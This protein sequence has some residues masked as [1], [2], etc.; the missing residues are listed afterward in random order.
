MRIYGAYLNA[1]IDGFIFLVADNGSLQGQNYRQLG[2][3]ITFQTIH[4]WT[5]N[6]DINEPFFR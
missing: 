1:D 3:M 4:A 2:H 5:T 6:F